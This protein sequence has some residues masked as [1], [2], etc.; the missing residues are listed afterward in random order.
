LEL[1]KKVTAGIKGYSHIDFSNDGSVLISGN[2]NNKFNLWNTSDLKLMSYAKEHK[3]RV[4]ALKFGPN[5]KFLASGSF[6][7]QVI[8]W[9]INRKELPPPVVE[10]IIPEPLTE[11]QGRNIESRWTLDLTNP[12]VVVKVWDNSKID[13]DVVTLYLNGET[14][15][16]QHSLI[17]AKETTTFTVKDNSTN[18]LILFADDL[19]KAP[20][21]TVALSISDGINTKNLTLRSDLEQSEAITLRYYPNKE[22]E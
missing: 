7:G 3:E 9:E 1:A 19:G 20:P 11:I 2:A 4:R 22:E 5:G 17:R 8:L 10:E 12:N 16:E 13:G 21:A 6:D 18:V 14:I 15:L